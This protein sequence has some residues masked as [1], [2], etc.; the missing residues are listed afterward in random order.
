MEA[1]KQDLIDKHGLFTA[2][3]VIDYMD[4]PESNTYTYDIL[5]HLIALKL[6][7]KLCSILSGVPYNPQTAFER[8]INDFTDHFNLPRQ[9]LNPKE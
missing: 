4:L 5:K 8:K 3:T 7:D 6:P 9:K 2:K 1:W